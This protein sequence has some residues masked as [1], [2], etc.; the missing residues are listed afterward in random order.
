MPY[1]NPATIADRFWSKVAIIPEH[2]CWE[3]IA[4]KESNGYG[5][6]GYGP[7]TYVAH[8]ISWMLHYGEMPSLCV[9]HSCD[10][11]GCVNPAHLFLGTRQD[12]NLDAMRKD[13]L[14]RG[15]RRATKL[16]ESDVA[17][18]RRRV[19]SERQI[20]LAREFGVHPSHISRTVSGNKWR[21]R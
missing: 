6:I 2:E 14:C 16:S 15:E 8:R 20:D 21:T 18:I 10:N 4:G 19:S 13:R 1:S 9:L 11:R 7:R 5:S 3:W 17:D 12:N